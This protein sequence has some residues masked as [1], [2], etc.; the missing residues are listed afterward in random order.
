MPILESFEGNRRLH[1]GNNSVWILLAIC[2]P[3]TKAEACYKYPVVLYVHRIWSLAHLQE[4]W[5][6]EDGS[7]S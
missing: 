6:S 5:D 1:S 4:V 2:L 7:E 3:L